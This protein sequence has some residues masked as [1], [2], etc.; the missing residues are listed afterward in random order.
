MLQIQMRDLHGFMVTRHTLLTLKSNG[1][2]NWL[3][4]ALARHLTGDIR[5]AISVIDIYLGTL[6]E[7]S[8]ELDRGFESSE[9][10][11]YRNSLLAEVPN[12]YDEA[13]KH[14]DDCEGVVV[15]RG[16]WMTARAKYQLK[17]GDFDEA[18][19]TTLQLLERGMTED[20]RI[21]SLYMMCILKLDDEEIVDNALRL[22]GTRTLASFLPLT[23][24]Q[25][26]TL[27]AAYRDEL[28][29]LYPKSYAVQRIPL[30]LIDDQE[31]LVAALDRFCRKDLTKGVPSLC[32]ELA[33]LLLIEKRGVLVKAG[34]PVDIR[35][36]P[37]F[38]SVVKMVDGYVENLT[39]CNKFALSDESEEA[40]STL[41][42]T[43]YLRAGLYE[44]EA[45]Y[46]KG[47]QVL[48]QCLEHT[49]TAVDVYELKARLLRA[50]G[51]IKT[52]VD[53]LDQGR[54][55]DRQDRYINNQTTRYMLLAGMEE[56]ALK[57]ISLFTRHEGNPEQ[58]LF[59]M[60]CSWYELELAACMRRK[61]EWGRSL[62]KFCESRC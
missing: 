8:P 28:S 7:G 17:L 38:Q 41:L 36:H 58:N 15:D 27:R 4:F 54:D 43:L 13:L 30:A 5:G 51:D 19:K 31:E 52:A 18:H 2:P 11:L 25:K 39:S 49:P 3:A 35:N 60:Q 26:Q 62:K 6:T 46:I 40:P 1:K 24:E 34:D 23:H 57:R 12:N 56:E 59:D 14:L 45:D 44:L 9:L 61:G 10:A 48:D 37:T 20:F 29:Q 16:A 50:A 22:Q 53:T 55:L 32:S 47:V 33:C 42:W 21:H